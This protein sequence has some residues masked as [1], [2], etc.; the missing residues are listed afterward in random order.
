MM[1]NSNYPPKTV[2]KRTNETNPF[3]KTT[4]IFLN[5]SPR[6]TILSEKPLTN[7]DKPGTSQ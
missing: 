1:S 6:S 3:R 7:P 4:F 5:S 2:Y